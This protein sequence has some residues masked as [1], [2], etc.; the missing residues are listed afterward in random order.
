[1]GP[2]FSEVVNR[3]RCFSSF[4]ERGTK[5]KNL[6]PHEE[7]SLIETQNFFPLSHARDKTKKH[8]ALFLYRAQ[9]LLSLAYYIYEIIN[10]FPDL[11]ILKFLL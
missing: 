3:G 8:L 10:V 11:L 7:S 2:T 5:E 9:N 1:M 6:S 4:H